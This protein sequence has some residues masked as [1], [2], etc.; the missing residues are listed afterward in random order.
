MIALIDIVFSF[1]SLTYSLLLDRTS[2]LRTSW[3]PSYYIRQSWGHTGTTAHFHRWEKSSMT[4]LR[5]LRTLWSDHTERHKQFA[6]TDSKYRACV[7]KG[8]P[9]NLD[10]SFLTETIVTLCGHEFIYTDVLASLL[11]KIKDPLRKL[12]FLLLPQATQSNSTTEHECLWKVH[13]RGLH[14]EA[15]SEG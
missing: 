7:L 3:H 11:K 15:R 9:A 14:H 6:I 12:Y 13:N 1:I 8:R 2:C 10:S 5:P 4:K